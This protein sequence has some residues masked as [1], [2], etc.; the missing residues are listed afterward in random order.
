MYA[1][2]ARTACVQSCA[3]GP[4]MSV[5][6]GRWGRRLRAKSRDLDLV[7][8]WLTELAVAT[9]VDATAAA[10]DWT[11]VYDEASGMT[12]ASTAVD[13]FL[14]EARRVARSTRVDEIAVHQHYD[15][16]PWNVHIKGSNPMLIDWETD[17]LRPADCLGPPL[18]DVLYLVTYWYFQT[19]RAGSDSDEEAAMVAL[20]ATPAPADRGVVAARMAIDRALRGLGLERRVIPAVLAALWAERAVYTH[21]RRAGLSVPL[22]PGRSRPDAYLRA[23][24]D[25]MPTM[26]A[27]D[28]W[29]A[30]PVGSH[31]Q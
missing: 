31:P 23:L 7:V 16:G 9:K 19:S 2:M 28:G 1:L 21:R 10:R 6:V 5:T 20:F 4:A 24:A 30:L 15:A 11:L 14:A 18:A 17:D 3:A 25:A 13:A 26:L 27:P 8:D 29:W 22:E 12:E